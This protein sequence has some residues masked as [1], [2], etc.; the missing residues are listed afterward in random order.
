MVEKLLAVAKE[1]AGKGQI[2]LTGDQARATDALLA[3]ADTFRAG[4]DQALEELH[5]KHAFER[6]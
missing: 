1:L 4:K 3:Q 5:L 2:E 6:A